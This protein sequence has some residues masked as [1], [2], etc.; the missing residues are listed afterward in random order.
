MILTTKRGETNTMADTNQPKVTIPP[1]PVIKAVDTRAQSGAIDPVEAPKP[2]IPVVDY[3]A[4]VNKYEKVLTEETPYYDSKLFYTAMNRLSAQNL[5]DKPADAAF[6]KSLKEDVTNY[7]VKNVWGA[8][9]NATNV[10]SNMIVE[11]VVA[12]Y[13]GISDEFLESVIEDGKDITKDLGKRIAEQV[14]NSYNKQM[15]NNVVEKLRGTM[16]NPE[17]RSALEALVKFRNGEYKLGIKEDQLADKDKLLQ[18]YFTGIERT[19]QDQGQNRPYRP[20]IRA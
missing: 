4:M 16:G 9:F 7:F 11:N 12:Q 17:G 14:A 5:A 19:L 15:T 8:T 20:R 18:G 10:S 13:T 6:K 1:Q 2:T 3:T